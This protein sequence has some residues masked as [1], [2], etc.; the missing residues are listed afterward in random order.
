M[1]T[2]PSINPQLPP[3]LPAAAPSGGAFSKQAALFSVLAPVASIVINLL[4]HQ[5]VQG[6]RAATIVLGSACTLLIL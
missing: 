6:N 5:A 4:G 2:P 3:P 1:G